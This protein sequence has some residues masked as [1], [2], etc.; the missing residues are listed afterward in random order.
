MAIQQDTAAL[1]GIGAA[2]SSST[3]QKA[4]LPAAGVQP[5]AAGVQPPAVR[6]QPRRSNSWVMA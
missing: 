6:V 4:A 5:P 3:R 2:P 1:T